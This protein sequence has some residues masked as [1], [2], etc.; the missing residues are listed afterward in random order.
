MEEI[1]MAFIEISRPIG[2]RRA[3]FSDLGPLQLGHAFVKAIRQGA[4]DRHIRLPREPKDLDHIAQ[5][6][7]ERLVDED[8][9]LRRENRSHLLE[10]RAAIEAGDEHG[11]D[12]AAELLDRWHELNT[13]FPLHRG[14]ITLDAIG[15][16]GHVGTE[17]FSP[18]RRPGH[19][20]VVRRAGFM[21]RPGKG[22]AMRGIEADRA[23][24]GG[25]PRMVDGSVRRGSLS[26]S[27]KREDD[28]RASEC[29]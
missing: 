12:L 1:G 2:N 24:T 25:R 17:R 26:A 6:S 4:E 7:G 28:G 11:I 19:R 20:H 21:E 23:P 5:G 18:Q 29:Q 15:A 9:F 22:N 16:R 13:E 14:G 27:D 10:M 8:P 3:H